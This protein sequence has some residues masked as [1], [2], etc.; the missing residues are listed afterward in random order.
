MLSWH[1]PTETT[2]RDFLDRQSCQPF[3][4]TGVGSSCTV[5]PA[6]YVLDHRR[7]RLGTGQ[8]VFQ[9]ACV[10]LRRWQMFQVGWVQ[11]CWP[12]A[13]LACGTVVGVLAS[14]CG[15]WVLN[16]CRIVYVL[17]DLQPVRRFGF[18][19]GT[20]PG[21]VERGEERFSIEWRHD[22]TVWYDLL[23]F[24][25]PGHWLLW[26]GYPWAR[27]LQRRFALASLAAMARAVEPA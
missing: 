12:T 18:A 27:R 19:Y 25:R 1:R 15:V 17:D 5:P 9:R 7:V 3:S 14:W 23:A 11:L 20:L 21:H 10:A 24:S 8:R 13:G 6:G 22:D 4:Y 26:L 2:I 16:A